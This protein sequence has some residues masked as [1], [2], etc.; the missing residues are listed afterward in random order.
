MTTALA[1]AAGAYLALRFAAMVRSALADWATLIQNSRRG[2]RNAIA[3]YRYLKGT[4]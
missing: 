4:D 1:V 2:I 3:R